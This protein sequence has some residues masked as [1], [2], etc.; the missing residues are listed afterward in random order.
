MVFLK[1]AKWTNNVQEMEVPQNEIQVSQTFIISRVIAGKVYEGWQLI[2]KSYFKTKLS[3][4]LDEELD[5]G[6]LK[7]LGELKK[8]FSQTNIISRVRNRFAFHY[9]TDEVRSA[10]Q[11]L[12]SD[13]EGMN[14]YVS[15]LPENFFYQMSEVVVARAMLHGIHS[16][17][18]SATLKFTKETRDTAILFIQFADGCLLNMARKYVPSEKARINRAS[19]TIADSVSHHDFY[20]PFFAEIPQND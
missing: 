19:K 15:E 9:G 4:A 5:P 13:D 1:F 7:S 20:L 3:K 2:R 12:H 10:V 18:E 17:L 11:N 6:T 14:I 8:Y 16:N